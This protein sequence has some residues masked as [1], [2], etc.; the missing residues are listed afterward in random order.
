MASVSSSSLALMDAGVPIKAPAAGIAL[1]LVADGKGNYQILTDIQGPEDHYGDMDFKLAGTTKGMTALQMD[2][3]I[4]GINKSMLKQSLERAKKARLEILEK[5]IKLIKEP[6]P[7]LSPFAPRIITIKI[8]PDKIRE[9]IGPGGKVINEIIEKTGVDIDIQPSGLIYVTSDSKDS[10]KK[11]ISLVKN[12]TREVKRGEVFQGRVTRMLNFGAFVEILPKQ[13]G[14]IHIS[15]FS[16]S[17]AK[18]IR[19]GDILEV[20]VISI[21]EKGRINLALEKTKKTKYDRPKKR[22]N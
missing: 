19:T 12:I 15:E 3:K 22:R 21:D 10:A 11:A 2:V 9:V 20:K 6:R 17:E 4:E 7:D 16:P 5:M 13:E 18:K 14:L 8:N 1:G